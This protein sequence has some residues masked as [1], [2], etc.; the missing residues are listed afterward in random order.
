[1]AVVVADQLSDLVERLGVVVVVPVA[2]LVATLPELLEPLT[3]AAAVVVQ[4]ETPQAVLAGQALLFCPFQQP[5][6]LERLQ[7]RQR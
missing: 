1:V 6:I 5:T 7:V 3:R 4:A 2:E